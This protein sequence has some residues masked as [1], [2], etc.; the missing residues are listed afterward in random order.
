MEVKAGILTSRVCEDS[1]GIYEAPKLGRSPY[2]GR[3]FV[4]SAG[5]Y[6]LV[7]DGMDW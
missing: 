1:E 7:N 3:A 5:H 2:W 4:F 6:A